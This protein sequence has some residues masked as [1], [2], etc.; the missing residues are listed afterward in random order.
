MSQCGSFVAKHLHT[1]SPSSGHN[2]ECSTRTP[3]KRNSWVGRRSGAME[4]FVCM[5]TPPP[6]GSR[7]R[8]PLVEQMDRAR[9]LRPPGL[10]AV[11]VDDHRNEVE[12]VHRRSPGIQRSRR[13]RSGRVAPHRLKTPT[14]T[15]RGRI[16]PE[17]RPSCPLY[18]ACASQRAHRRRQE[19]QLRTIQKSTIVR[20]ER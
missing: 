6:E 19:N 4:A 8:W 10:L 16:G 5:T 7:G 1:E 11:R 9:R 17:S 15:A 13:C 14:S 18:R 20:A 2:S 12:H 3:S